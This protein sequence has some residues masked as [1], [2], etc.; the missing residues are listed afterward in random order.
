MASHVSA[1]IA[2][3]PDSWRR[4]GELIGPDLALP[5]PGER[6]AVVGCGTSW[7]MAMAYARL[8]EDAGQ[9]WTD[10]FAAS[11]FP[12]GRPYDVIVAISRS[13]TTTEV[14]DLLADRVGAARSVAIVGVAGTPIAEAA[15]RRIV[16]DFADEQSVVQTRFATTTLALLR[17][18]LGH[19]LTRLIDHAER[20]LSE[21][22]P[23]AAVTAEQ[24]TFLGHGWTVGVAHEAALK[25]REAA[26]SWTES[27]PAYDY[28]HGPIAISAPGRL[29]WGFGNMPDGLRADVQGTGATFLDSDLDPLAHLITAQRVAVARA[30]ALGL[31]PDR[32]RS[33][34]RSVILEPADPGA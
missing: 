9:G 7:F 14:T 28:R 34:T 29:V 26:Q 3:Q 2:S 16:L 6:V 20:A 22:V 4:V 23:G 12:A 1:E 21:P 27:Y 18:H 33:L 10:A 5:I 15:D 13:G 24:L 31:D 19:D 11:E 8:R 25:L 32:P 30:E 17:A